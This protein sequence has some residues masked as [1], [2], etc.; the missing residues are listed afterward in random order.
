MIERSRG[1]VERLENRPTVQRAALACAWAAGIWLL[2]S[3]P[4]LGPPAGVVVVFVFNGG[5]FV[6]FGVLAALSALALGARS[7]ARRMAAVGLAAAWGVLD[8]LHQRSVPG[9][10]VAVLDAITDA[11]GAWFAVAALSFLFSA[12]VG[13]RRAMF[14]A[15]ALGLGAVAAGTFL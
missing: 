11:S 3:R 5:H 13:A 10:D 15:A 6:L 1:L 9:R 8:E 2:S 14:V 12:S 4:S 7:R